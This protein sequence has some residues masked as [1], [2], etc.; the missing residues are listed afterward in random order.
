MADE[1]TPVEAPDSEQSPPEAESALEDAE[2]EPQVSESAP[3]TTES[4]SPWRAAR[5]AAVVTGAVV[6][7]AAVVT[8][9]VW[10]IAAIVDDDDDYH[11]DYAVPY[12]EEGYYLESVDPERSRGAEFGRE[13]H[14]DR[15]RRDERLDRRRGEGSDRGWY[16]QGERGERDKGEREKRR[17]GKTGDEKGDGRADERADENAD[18]SESGKADAAKD[19]MTVLQFGTGDD[20]VTVLVCNAPRA[21][22][23]EFESDRDRDDFDFRSRPR[24]FFWFSPFFPPFRD[25]WPFEGDGRPFEEFREFNE[26]DGWPFGRG[27]V[28]FEGDGRPFEEFGEL[29]GDGVPFDFEG[30]LGDLFRDGDR[31]FRFRSDGDENGFCFRQD[32]E[33]R[34]LSDLGQLSDE[35]REQLEQMM[36]MLENFGIGSFFGGLQGFFEELEPGSIEAPTGASDATS[37]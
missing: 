13:P 25:G 23:P 15:D 2:Q 5:V 7:S 35:E 1:D 8:G 26:Q 10:A 4:K 24:N 3:G 12:Y 14:A 33:E 32:G 19:C 29:F 17:Y 16:K 30:E 20:A 31:G 18:G 37:T 28:P 27:E 11:D 21:E 6:A 22:W 34:C 36:E 9:A